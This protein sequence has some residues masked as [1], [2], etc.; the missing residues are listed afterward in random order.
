M[1]KLRYSS[2]E[3]V[4]KLQWVERLMAKGASLGEAAQAVG[5]KYGTVYQWRRRYGE[6]A[7]AGV[8]ALRRLQ[9]ENARLRQALLELELAESPMRRGNMRTS[10]GN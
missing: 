1:S 6:L 9:A 3:I 5:V 4:S 10:F 7:A 2:D 8:D